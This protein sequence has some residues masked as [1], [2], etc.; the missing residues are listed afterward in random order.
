[1]IVTCRPWRY[2]ESPSENFHFPWETESEFFV[3][4]SMQNLLHSNTEYN[5]C[6]HFMFCTLK[7]L[8]EI[9]STAQPYVVKG[10]VQAQMTI[11]LKS[12][13]CFVI[14]I[15]IYINLLRLSDAYMRR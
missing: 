14:Y 13:V 9:L 8:N 2:Y 12:Y 5:M 7:T 6:K 4:L 1:M 15:H 3:F 10:S 11:S